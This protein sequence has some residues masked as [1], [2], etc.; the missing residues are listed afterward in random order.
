MLRAVGRTSKACLA[1]MAAAS[2][3]SAA[4]ASAQ[5]PL[6]EPATEARRLWE[7][8]RDLAEADRC[9]DALGFFRRSRALVER[10][11]TV[12][13][14]GT[15][16]FTLGRHVEAVAAFDD[17]LRIADSLRDAEYVRRAREMAERSRHATATLR[18]RTTPATATV[19]LDGR[20]VDGAGEVRVV[21]VDPGEHVLR[22][23]APGYQA[24]TVQLSMLPGQETEQTVSLRVERA[25]EAGP[26]S[27][28]RRARPPP[29]ESPSLVGPMV[30]LGVSVAAIVAAG[31]FF[32]VRES[33]VTDRDAACDESGCD[34]VALDHDERARTYTTLTN[35]ALGSGA[36]VAAGGIVWLVVQLAGGRSEGE[37]VA[38]TPL[39][40]GMRA[41]LRL[42]F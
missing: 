25:A 40:D 36:V 23:S 29:R 17:Y 1:A 33:A 35:V 31:G 10:P 42:R 7:Q 30:T 8:G 18:L 21:P 12:F 3:C 11:S 2:V 34:D 28:P 38:L 37:Q 15:C 41:Q 24:A 27:P 5:A 16:L 14:I 20:R 22:I 13:S 39:R 32:F 6:V 9:G 4:L 26:R 19:T